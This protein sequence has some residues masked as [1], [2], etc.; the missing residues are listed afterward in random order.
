MA[1][2]LLQDMAFAK[3]TTSYLDQQRPE[4]LVAAPPRCVQLLNFARA[5]P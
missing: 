3:T 4:L 5:K 2:L 1:L